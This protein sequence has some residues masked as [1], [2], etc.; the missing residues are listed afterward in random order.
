M[1]EVE[2]VYNLNPSVIVT[3][4]LN[5]TGA[6]SNTTTYSKGDS[7]SYNGSSYVALQ[8]TTGHLPTNSTYWQLIAEEGPQGLPGTGI[9]KGFTIAMATAL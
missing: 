1:A 5:P 8:S 2:L 7:V 6:Y 9:S 3:G 4:G